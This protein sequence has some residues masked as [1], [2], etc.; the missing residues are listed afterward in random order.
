MRAR[1]RA[2]VLSGPFKTGITQNRAGLLAEVDALLQQVRNRLPSSDAR[3]GPL[4]DLTYSGG[5]LVTT[6]GAG[7]MRQRPALSN[8]AN[9]I[10]ATAKPAFTVPSIPT[11]RAAYP[12]RSSSGRRTWRRHLSHRCG[13]AAGSSRRD[14]GNVSKGLGPRCPARATNPGGLMLRIGSVVFDDMEGETPLVPTV[15]PRVRRGTLLEA[16][17]TAPETVIYT[18]TSGSFVL[19][20]ASGTNHGLI[21][22]AKRNDLIALYD[23]GQPFEVQTDMTRA[24]GDVANYPN[25]YFAP[26]TPPVFA[27]SEV[28]DYW[29]YDLAIRIPVAAL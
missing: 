28:L 7:M 12:E 1:G 6:F 4:S 8:V 20:F 5:K 2:K 27:P 10:A 9:Q 29:L 18:G 26:D 19:R 13:W 3:V 22:V 15:T 14:F 24:A 21:G 16:L 11:S 23:G 17:A 25:C